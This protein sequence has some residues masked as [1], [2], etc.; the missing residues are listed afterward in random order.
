MFECV[1]RDAYVYLPFVIG[2]GLNLGAVNNAL[3]LTISSHGALVSP[4]TIAQSVIL[5]VYSFKG[6]N[7][8]GIDHTGDVRHAAIAHF[9]D[10][11]I[12]NFQ[13]F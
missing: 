13:Q 5:V 2:G 1:L 3:C 12:R 6:A 10:V 8:M 7:V 11:L 4:S 9:H